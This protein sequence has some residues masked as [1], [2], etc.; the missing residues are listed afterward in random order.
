MLMLKFILV[1]FPYQDFWSR[2]KNL[3]WRH[4][5]WLSKT[6]AYGFSCPK[7]LLR[8]HLILLLCNGTVTK[9][10]YN[11]QKQA[12]RVE[13]YHLNGMMFRRLNYQVLLRLQVRFCHLDH[14]LQLLYLKL[15]NFYLCDWCVLSLRFLCEDCI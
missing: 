1:F 12:L 11:W 10:L 8:N 6:H 3:H 14:N 9:T 2:L 4:A 13:H 15:M 5:T 7:F